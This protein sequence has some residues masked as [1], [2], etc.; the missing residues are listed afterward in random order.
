MLY[1]GLWRWYINITITVLHTV[2]LCYKPEGCCFEFRRAHQFFFSLPNPSSRIMALRFTQP[3]TEMSSRSR[4]MFL[5]SSARPV[6]KADNLAAICEPI[7][8]KMWNIDV[9]Q[10]Y[11]SPR[12]V[13]GIALLFCFP[14]TSHCLRMVSHLTGNFC[15][16]AANSAQWQYEWMKGKTRTCFLL[17]P[18]MNGW[19]V[20]TAQGGILKYGARKPYLLVWIKRILWIFIQ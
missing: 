9:S 7:I 8:Y 12:A 10:P 13:T 18:L 11:W 16:S 3:L 1:I 4:K 17:S 6:R 2:V 19:K 14:F 15:N 20:S 5:R